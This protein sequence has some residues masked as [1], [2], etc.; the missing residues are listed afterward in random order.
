MAEDLTEAAKAVRASFIAHA[1]HSTRRIRGVKESLEQLKDFPERCAS[2]VNSIEEGFSLT[3]VKIKDMNLVLVR[4]QSDFPQFPVAAKAMLDRINGDEDLLNADRRVYFALR[5][6]IKNR[7][8]DNDDVDDA[9]SVAGAAGHVAVQSATD[10]YRAK[11]AK[12][13][14]PKEPLTLDASLL[15]LDIWIGAFEDYAVTSKIITYTPAKS[16]HGYLLNCL[17]GVLRT[18]VGQALKEDPTIPIRKPEPQENADGVL[19]PS[20]QVDCFDLIAKAFEFKYPRILRRMKFSQARMGG[21]DRLLDWGGKLEQMARDADI[22]AMTDEDWLAII[23]MVGINN[24]KLRDELLKVR[25]TEGEKFIKTLMRFTAEWDMAR[26]I[27]NQLKTD[28][29]QAAGLSGYKKGQKD[30][31]KQ[32]QGGTPAAPT[33]KKGGGPKGGGK[34]ESASDENKKHCYNCGAFFGPQHKANCKAKEAT[35]KACNKKGH[36]SGK[37]ACDMSKDKK[38]SDGKEVTASLRFAS[39][40]LSDI[41]GEGSGELEIIDIVAGMSEESL[42]DDKGSEAKAVC[43]TG[44][45]HSVI[46]KQFIKSIYL[47]TSDRRAIEAANGTSVRCVGSTIVWVEYQG[48]RTRIHAYVSPSIDDFYLSGKDLRRMRI[49]PEKFP[50]VILSKIEILEAAAAGIIKISRLVPRK[51]DLE[52]V[53]R[54]VDRVVAKHKI[55]FDTEI[56]RPMKGPKVT[57][58]LRED[59]VIKPVCLV[60]ARTIPL[61]YHVGAKAALDEAAAGP[62]PVISPVTSKST[63]AEWCHPALFVPKKDGTMRLC[64]DFKGINQHIVRPSKPFPTA[65]EIA[66]SIPASTAIFA[67]LDLRQGYHQV[68]LDEASKDKTTF[69]TMWGRWRYNRACMGLASSGDEFVLRTDEALA[70]LLGI[71]KLVDDILLV[72][73]NEEQFMERFALLVQRCQDN[74]ITLSKKKLQVGTE[75][76]FGGMIV[77]TEGIRADP[78]KVQAIKEFPRPENITDMRSFCGLCNQ[79]GAYA[80]DLAHA[81]EPLRKLL[82]K[83]IVWQ[84][85]PEHQIA[86]DQVRKV[87]TCVDGPVLAHFDPTLETIILTDASNLHGIGYCLAQLANADNLDSGMRLIQAGSRGL[88]GAEKNYSTVELEAKCIEWAIK[89]C[90]L[91]VSG[92]TFKVFTDH[93]PLRPIFNTKSLAEIDNNRLQRIVEKTMGYSFTVD[94]VAGK[95]HAIADALSRYPVFAPTEDDEAEEAEYDTPKIVVSA[96][97]VHKDLALEDVSL[98]GKADEHYQMVLKMLKTGARPSPASQFAHL[99]PYWDELSHDGE[100]VYHDGHL[101]VP[102]ILRDKLLGDLHAGHQG[103]EYTLRNAKQ[104][105]FWVGMKNDVKNRVIHCVPCQIHQDSQQREPLLLTTA[106]RPMESCGLDLFQPDDGGQYLIMTD[107]YSGFPWVAELQKLTA[108]G[109]IRIMD[110]WFTDFGLPVQL[111]SDNGPQ[112]R[113]EFSDYCEKMRI[114]FEPSSPR[115]AQSN[116]AAEAA[117]KA[118]KKLLNKYGCDKAKFRS[119][120]REWR[121]TPKKH[122]FSPASLFF[123]YRQ[124]TL[125]PATPTAYA[126]LTQED[127]RRYEAERSKHNDSVTKAWNKRSKAIEVL[128]EGDDVWIQ[129]FKTKRWTIRGKVLRPKEG[130]DRTYIVDCDGRQL[131]RNRRLLRP[132]FEVDLQA[133]QDA[134]DDDYV[135]NLEH[136][137]DVE[138]AQLPTMPRRS[139]R[140]VKKRAEQ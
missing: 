48:I 95:T 111:R 39:I 53:M 135:D 1:G 130:L 72:A 35:C 29:V 17:K 97:Q 31:Q 108:A 133:Y 93:K 34:P 75:V 42:D 121:N 73:D 74:G 20:E 102:R 96:L 90:K 8:G 110:D 25:K 139:E 46:S 88:T 26:Q 43:D 44:C 9:D 123:G 30:K 101:F 120:L 69:I 128:A 19:V 118:M 66:A 78:G 87:L 57:I 115:F 58:K 56:L 51:V 122:G 63:P 113:K 16:Q 61:A 5:K 60:N 52:K 65:S 3:E 116:G 41:N 129:D 59:A 117:V 24:D 126:R 28:P 92:R 64:V 37:P 80:P 33:D 36:Y 107:R 6:A 70:G 38:K 94:W 119:A 68:E 79:L 76:T 55:V 67:V 132:R 109:S 137:L 81:M 91:Y 127:F 40:K 112:F 124:R 125:L 10:A 82:Q 100:L 104:L 114:D 138:A 98:A 85:L 71:Q 77:S 54:E 131:V 134:V 7:T 13:L 18:E 105:Y 22:R 99:E 89:K 49:L 50:N 84:W 103:L 11:H 15:D 83:G 21:K 23:Y 47:D 4:F 12:D 45:T 32:A 27:N 136:D 86:F 140:L 2:L 14:C 62:M 106:S